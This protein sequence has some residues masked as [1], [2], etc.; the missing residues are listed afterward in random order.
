MQMLLQP[1]LFAVFLSSQNS[2]V[3]FKYPSP[4]L[5]VHEVDPL[6]AAVL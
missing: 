5:E 4:Q 6:F 3:E 2:E 1:S